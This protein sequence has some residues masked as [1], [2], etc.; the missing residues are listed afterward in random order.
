ML[1]CLLNFNT[2]AKQALTRTHV[3]ERTGQPPG[4][5]GFALP[6]PYADNNTDSA[7]RS[8]H[9]D[10]P[11]SGMQQCTVVCNFQTGGFTIPVHESDHEQYMTRKWKRPD[12][13]AKTREPNGDG[14]LQCKSATSPSGSS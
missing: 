6:C 13:T 7:V 1:Q 10:M 8:P 9:A 12:R 4:A 11:D 5:A 2:L 14:A 3:P